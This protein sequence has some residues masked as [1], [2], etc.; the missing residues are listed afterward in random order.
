[1]SRAEPG[2]IPPP[3]TRSSSVMP[4]GRRCTVWVDPESDSRATARPRDRPVRPVPGGDTP[5]SLSST[6]VF[7]S[8]QLAHLPVQRLK[9]APQFWQTNVALAGLAI[10]SIQLPLHSDFGVSFGPCGYAVARADDAKPREEGPEQMFGSGSSPGSLVD[11]VH[12]TPE[13]RQQL[14]ADGA[15]PV[16]E[17]VECYPVA[18]NLYPGATIDLI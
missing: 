5:T 2:T 18:H 16:R 17:V 12:P 10:A 8:S 15:G 11:P 1:M 9:T 13:A 7:H 3:V 4:V 14:V 6:S